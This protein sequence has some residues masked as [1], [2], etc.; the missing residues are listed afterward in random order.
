MRDGILNRENVGRFVVELSRPYRLAVAYAQELHG[1]SNPVARSL[2]SSI[3][4]QIHLLLAP[5]SKRVFLRVS[6]GEYGA[7]WSDDDFFYIA[8][9]GYQGVSHAHFKR[10]VP[11]I[12]D[13][14]REGKYCD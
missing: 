13:E 6:V 4:H 14:R 9:L 5:G 11:V 3:Q 8:Q 10:F 12:C 2:H 1:D 7:C